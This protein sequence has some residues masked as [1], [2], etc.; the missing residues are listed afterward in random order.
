MEYQILALN[1]R[2]D[3]IRVGDI[4]DDQMLHRVSPRRVMQI[5]NCDDYFTAIFSSK[6]KLEAHFKHLGIDDYEI[7]PINEEQ[8]FFE[9]VRTLGV[10]LMVDPQCLDEH[11]TRWKEIIVDEEKG[12]FIISELN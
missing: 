12:K 11:H 9:F 4:S 7:C 5:E 2:G 8:D 3:D 10:R 6:E 1:G